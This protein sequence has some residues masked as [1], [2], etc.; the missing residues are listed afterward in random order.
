MGENMG[1]EGG[2]NTCEER[3]EGEG[4]RGYVRRRGWREKERV[5]EGKGL[6]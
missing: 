3:G 1:G 2:V 6:V 4:W 5:C